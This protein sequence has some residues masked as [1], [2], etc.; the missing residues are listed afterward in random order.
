MCFDKK[1]FVSRNEIFCIIAKRVCKNTRFLQTL[2]LFNAKKLAA[3]N[4]N[5]PICKRIIGGPDALRCKTSV[6]ANN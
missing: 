2:F 1:A 6:V 5:L 3:E 4:G